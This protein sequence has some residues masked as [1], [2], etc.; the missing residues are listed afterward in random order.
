MKRLNHLLRV[1]SLIILIFPKS[2]SSY[3]SLPSLTTLVGL[4]VNMPIRSTASASS[5]ATID[6][7][8][9][10]S[11][12][13]EKQLNQEQKHS[14]SYNDTR[15]ASPDGISCGLWLAPSTLRGAGIGM[16][17]GRNFKKGDILQQ[18]GDVVVPVIDLHYHQPSPNLS[19][20]WDECT[21]FDC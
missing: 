8:D 12:E 19:F 3:A 16:F 20:H 9:P 14:S 7:L 4:L 1:A 6:L 13:L 5:R 15:K 17:A 2:S 11:S 21:Y 10:D 18:S